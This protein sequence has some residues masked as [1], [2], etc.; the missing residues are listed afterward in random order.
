MMGLDGVTAAGG[1]YLLVLH[2]LRRASITVG[3]LGTVTIAPGWY[4]YVGSALGPGG[5]RGRLRHHLRPALRPHWHIDSLR[6]VCKVIAVGYV[7][8]DH[9]WEHHWAAR[10]A[11]LASPAPCRGF[12]ASD[13]RCV[14]H[15][16]HLDAAPELAALG[17]ALAYVHPDHPPV[18]W[19]TVDDGVLSPPAVFTQPS[20]A[21]KLI[22]T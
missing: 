18:Q 8:D 9:R 16:F 4:L 7:V 22:G 20:P 13:C 6:Q 2:P 3:R 19:S 11:Q 10:L 5:L 15:G 14:A 17:V 1:A 21:P 12:G